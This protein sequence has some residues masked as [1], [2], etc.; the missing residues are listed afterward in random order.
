[1]KKK[2]LSALLAEYKKGNIN[3][4]VVQGYTDFLVEENK[5]TME[6]QEVILNLLTDGKWGKKRK[7]KK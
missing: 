2:G 1:M 6:V 5:M 7:K 3:I 4:F